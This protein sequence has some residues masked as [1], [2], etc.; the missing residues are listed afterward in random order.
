MG[1]PFTP[2]PPSS[3]GCKWVYYWAMIRTDTLHI[4]PEVLGLI[5]RID[6]FKGAWRALGM[7]APDRLSALRRVATIESIGSSTRIE[8]SRLSDMDLDPSSWSSAGSCPNCCVAPANFVMQVRRTS[9]CRSILRLLVVRSILPVWSRRCLTQSLSRRARVFGAGS[10]KTR[11]LGRRR[12]NSKMIDWR[13]LR[14]ASRGRGILVE[15]LGVFAPN[16]MQCIETEAF[17]RANPQSA[18]AYALLRLG[19]ASLKSKISFF[20]NSSFPTR[21]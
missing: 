15:G 11:R 20:G 8:G 6:E 4:T 18:I 9:T 3:N 21:P 7:L 2:I 1:R 10:P 17:S 12:L 14:S 19:P 13:E 16:I 5:A